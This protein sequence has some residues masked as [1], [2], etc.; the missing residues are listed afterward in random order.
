MPYSHDP[1]VGRV[2]A[3]ARGSMA[4]RSA[5]GVWGG[6]VVSHSVDAAAQGESPGGVPRRRRAP[7]RLRQSTVAK[8]PPGKAAAADCGGKSVKNSSLQKAQGVP[9]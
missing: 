6:L 5:G 9:S 3:V 7:R 1:W 8:A 4:R 2:G